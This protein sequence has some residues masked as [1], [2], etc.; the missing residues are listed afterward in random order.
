MAQRWQQLLQ[1]PNTVYNLW[2]L[3][4]QA[5]EHTLSNARDTILY[6]HLD[7][8]T[9]ATVITNHVLGLYQCPNAAQL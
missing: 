2:E 5:A 8:T 6:I 1:Q 7:A 4:F 3:L 9:D